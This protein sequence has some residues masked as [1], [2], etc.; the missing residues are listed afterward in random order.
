MRRELD[1]LIRLRS[2]RVVQ[3][4]NPTFGQR[5]GAITIDQI[6]IETLLLSNHMAATIAEST[7]R[8]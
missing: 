1:F 2:A 4:A 3:R 6:I 7:K 8:M 5:N